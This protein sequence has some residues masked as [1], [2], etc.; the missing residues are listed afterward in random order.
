CA[1]LVDG[2]EPPME[3]DVISSMCRNALLAFGAQDID[4]DTD[5]ICD[6]KL[7]PW[8]D[9]IKGLT[10]SARPPQDVEGLLPTPALRADGAVELTVVLGRVSLVGLST[11][12]RPHLRLTIVAGDGS[13]IDPAQPSPMLAID[14]SEPTTGDVRC[15]VHLQHPV[16]LL[17]RGTTIV[18]ELVHYKAEKQMES[19]KA[20]TYYP[21]T[22]I[23]DR[24]IE[25]DWYK[26]PT[27][28]TLKRLKQYGKE[29]N[30]VRQSL[31]LALELFC[32]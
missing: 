12:V 4:P 18:I 8:A 16:S 15:S 2:I 9:M 6:L 24:D 22:E 7:T 30:G 17:Q 23:S 27:D 26:K 21:L 20:F 5:D 11:L 13:V 19:V 28:F 1:T 31:K 3:L 32:V 29:K 10:I 25:L 14:P